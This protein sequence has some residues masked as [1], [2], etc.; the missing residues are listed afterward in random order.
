MMAKRKSA[1]SDALSV[2]NEIRRR[3]AMYLGSVQFFGLVNYLVTPVAMLLK[4]QPTQ[5]AISADEG[6]FIVEA[7]VALPVE[8]PPPR[9]GTVR[10]VTLFEEVGPGHDSDGCVLNAL[11]E[12]LKV[13]IRQ[14]DY[15]ARLAFHRGVREEGE[16]IPGQRDGPRTTMV[17]TPDASIFEVTEVSGAVFTSYLRR[18]SYL[19]QGVRF[20][21]RAGA[22]TQEFYAEKGIVDLFRVVTAPYQLMHEP[23]H[24]IAE[25]GELRIEAIFAYHSWI[26]RIVWC[27]INYGRAAEGGTHEE[28]L[29]D[30]LNQIYTK[31]KLPDQPKK[32][33]RNGVIGIVSIR[34][35]KTVWAG[36]V[37]ARVGNPELRR[38]V[39][40]LV[41]KGATDWLEAHPDVLKDMQKM[42]IFRFADWWYMQYE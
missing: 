41:V 31:F 29:D 8:P 39:R 36:C 2:I 17:F 25:H 24:F 11:S 37:K 4:R 26:E 38:M 7:D 34:Y 5:L 19:Y 6:A 40:D 14:A 30:A 3:P 15:T 21:L 35:P 42:E 32:D 33:R 16:W 18:L 23:I 28:G 13:E 1:P 27:F 9:R 12:T 20:S 10:K 22:Q